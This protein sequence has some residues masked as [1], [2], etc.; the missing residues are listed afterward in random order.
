MAGFQK[1]RVTALPDKFIQFFLAFQIKP[2]RQAFFKTMLGYQILRA[3]QFIEGFADKKHGIARGLKKRRDAEI[4]VFQQA[5]HA[6]GGR[7]IHRAFRIF[8]VETHISARHRCVERYAGIPDAFHGA[9]ELPEHFG[10]H[11]I[12]EIEAIRDAQG[13][14]A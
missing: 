13:H 4:N 7:G 2:R 1:F 8:I 6:D 5:G 14:G 11:G 9:A 3:A 12:A 10:L